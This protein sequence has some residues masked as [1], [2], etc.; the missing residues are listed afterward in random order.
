M[1]ACFSGRVSDDA[2]C[3]RPLRGG[4]LAAAMVATDWQG[5]YPR[6]P[7]SLVG[8][9]SRS[10]DCSISPRCCRPAMAEDLR[11]KDSICVRSR[12]CSGR[13]PRAD[14]R[15]GCRRPGIQRIPAP[16]PDHC[17]GMGEGRHRSRYEEIAGTDHF[18]VLDALSD[19]ELPDGEATGGAR[20]RER[21]DDRSHE[22]NRIRRMELKQHTQT[23]S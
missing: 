11:L 10:Q 9:P 8:R 2:S 15:C 23:S 1:P 16:E 14:V 17:G 7:A 13:R 5:L 12:P 22:T 18:T 4:D 19:P 3:L 20:P 21:L 6:A